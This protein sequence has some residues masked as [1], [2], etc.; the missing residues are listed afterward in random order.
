MSYVSRCIYTHLL[1]LYTKQGNFAFM[2]S[3]TNYYDDITP[4]F[5]VA[6]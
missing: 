2:V 3:T 5:A 1:K 4:A 6:S